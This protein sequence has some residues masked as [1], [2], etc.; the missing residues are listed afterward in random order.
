[1]PGQQYSGIFLQNWS[2]FVN[3]A[4]QFNV[5]LIIVQKYL[6]CCFQ[7]RNQILKA[8]E[9]LDYHYLLWIDSDILFTFDDFL[10]LLNKNVDFISGL[11]RLSDGKRFA[12]VKEFNYDYY[13]ENGNFEFLTENDLKEELVEITGYCGLGFALMKKEVIDA[14]T[15]PWFEQIK[16]PNNELATEDLSFCQKIKKA[17]FKI[18][19]DSSCRIGHLK[20]A[21]LI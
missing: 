21:I 15:Y 17:G 11:Y 9:K 20:N 4:V 13:K 2:Q 5:E 6:P 19:L 18:L 10:K 16:L 14:L 8:V 12:A 1:M 3:Y 7:V